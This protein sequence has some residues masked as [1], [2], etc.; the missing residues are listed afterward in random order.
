MRHRKL[1]PASTFSDQYARSGR[2]RRPGG[3]PRF[4]RN[5]TALPE[6]QARLTG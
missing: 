4:S 3:K 2:L 6:L 1:F 5:R